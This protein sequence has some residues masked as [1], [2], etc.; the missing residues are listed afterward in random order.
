MSPFSRRRRALLGFLPGLGLGFDGRAAPAWDPSAPPGPAAHWPAVVPGQRLQFPRDHG[1]HP[2]YRIEWWYV[3]GWLRAADGAD[4]GFQVT[5]FRHRPAIATGNPSRFTPQQLIF[6]HVALAEAAPGR[7]L[8][9]QR[10]AR[11]GFGHAAAGLG[12]ASVFLDRWRLG[13]DAATG[14]WLTHIAART[15]TLDLSL[16]PRGAPLLQGA[17]GFSRKGP[18]AAQA[19][20]YYSLPQLQVTGS[21]TRAGARSAVT[22]TAW[23]DHEWSSSVLDPAAAGWDWVG[24]NLA[25]GSALMAFRIRRRDGSVLWS[26]G[27]HQ[28]AGGISQTLAPGTLSFTTRRSWTSPQTG[29]SYPVEMTLQAAGRVWLLQPLRDDQ[30][31]D[32]RASSGVVYWEGAVRVRDQAGREVGRGYLELTGYFR[33]LR[34]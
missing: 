30:E 14:N 1:A 29:A 19:S 4:L 10:S 7:F 20:Y 3:T 34:L 31:L 11:A 2:D 5:F 28:S 32:S 6:A 33:A 13:R 12:D 26:G 27:T 24:L 21:V 17:A 16:A 22:G 23:L 8:H 25:D 9:D 18:Q 15:F